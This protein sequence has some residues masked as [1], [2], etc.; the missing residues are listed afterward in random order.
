MQVFEVMTA[1]VVSVRP[2]ATLR[3][4]AQLMRSMG[5]GPL[6]VSEGRLLVGMITDRDIAVRAA[7]EGRDPCTTEVR[8]VMT[9]EVVCCHEEDDV[10][11]AARLMRKAQ[12][13]RLAVVDSRGRLVGIVSQSDLPR[14]PPDALAGESRREETPAPEMRN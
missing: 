11:R 3:D 7:A 13:R 4:A 10:D 2:E 9:P 14:R 5:L 12:L 6:P 1:D 8:E